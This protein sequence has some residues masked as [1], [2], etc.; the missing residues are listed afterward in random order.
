MYFIFAGTKNTKIP[1]SRKDVVGIALNVAIIVLAIYP[2]FAFIPICYLN[3]DPLYPILFQNFQGNL[4]I[5]TSLF[6]LRILLCLPGAIE[7]ARIVS[8]TML[9]L[10]IGLKCALNSI[11]IL[12]LRSWQIS[13]RLKSNTLFLAH[14]QLTIIFSLII[15]IQSTVTAFLM[16]FGLV[17][18]VGYNFVTLKMH[19][20]I[21]MPLYLVFPSCSI[22][23]QGLIN[24]LIPLAISVY[25]D[26]AEVL[27]K[28]VYWSHKAGEGGYHA[29]CQ[30]RLR[31]TRPHWFGAGVG[32]YTLFV[33][34]KSTKVTFYMAILSYTIDSLLAIDVKG[35]TV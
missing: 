20:L 16:G 7:I 8:S 18:T 19:G 33:I 28:W 13:F 32:Q 25:E 17:G 10:T 1:D 26:S 4:F 3:L 9:I 22:L 15:I 29:L 31:S 11:R 23:M 30:R 2:Y 21:P 6:F 12:G 27:N 35:F 34:K 24:I 5:K 14:S